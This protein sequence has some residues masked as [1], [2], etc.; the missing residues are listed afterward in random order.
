MTTTS[1]LTKSSALTNHP[2]R[3]IL[4]TFF[5]WKFFLLLIAVGSTLVNDRAYD[6]S[7]DLLLIGDDE[8]LSVND[9]N[10]V[11]ELVRNFGKRLVTRF[12]SWDAIYFVSAAKRGYV[13]EQEWAFGTG[14]V[15]SVRGVLGALQTLG[16]PLPNSPTAL[17]EAVTAVLLS[18]ISH[19]LA[20]LVLYHLTLLL[21]L[22]SCISSPQKQRKL[23]LLTSV[24]FIFSPAGLFLSAPYAESSCALFSF[25]GWWFYA[26]SCLS[27]GASS[28]FGHDGKV[29]S[30][31]LTL[32][33]DLNVL[34]A[35]LSFGIA[36]LFRTNGILNGLPFAWE[37]LTIFSVFITSGGKIPL[38]KTLRRLI[39]L[40]LGGIFV[41]MGSIVPQTVAWMRYCP[42]GSLWL[43]NKF[44]SSSSGG[45]GVEV[46]ET[47]DVSGSGGYGASGVG[48]GVSADGGAL[49]GLVAREEAREWC[50]AV[51]PSIYTFVQEH[52]WN[53]GFLRYWTLPN[54]PL[55]LLAAPM[56]TILV[57]SGLDQLRQRPQ[58][59]T[60]NSVEKNNKSPATASG[61]TSS[62]AAPDP[63]SSGSVKSD[64]E[65]TTT[66]AQQRMQILIHSAAAEQVLLAVLAVSTYHV[67]II[68]RISS[69]YPLWY[70]WLAQQLLNDGDDGDQEKKKKKKLG[71]GIVVFMVMYAAIQGV[72]FTSF[73][74]PA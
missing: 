28:T 56:L 27:D 47:S 48:A 15:A 16:L 32:K 52:Y 24:L 35:G 26:R 20:S 43:L 65:P 5:L 71:R 18:N 63:S 74:P 14:L 19:L 51:V 46:S 68:T 21:P 72:L 55:F 40:L 59:L 29:G 49:E 7:A 54:I 42:S 11:A 62:S 39:A 6:T 13:Y 23:A 30:S 17:A 9:G 2:H 69:G 34:L 57:K 22:S 37:V 33:G 67:Q 10:G 3:T 53:V 12:N 25:L 1:P 70:W 61:T 38:L 64:P 50:A 8:P 73:L 44:L 31:S 58:Q 4:K 45:G 66:P 60:A 41:A 36:T